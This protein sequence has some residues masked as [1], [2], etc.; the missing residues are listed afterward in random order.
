MPSIALASGGWILVSVVVLIMV[1][2]AIGL[3]SR[4]GSEISSHPRGRHRGG[5]G[6]SVSPEEG[7]LPGSEGR[8][9]PSTRGTR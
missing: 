3:F 8:R 5:G 1:G 9:F 7:E 4:A 6:S 2:V